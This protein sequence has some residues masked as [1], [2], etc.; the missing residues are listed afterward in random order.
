LRVD[1]HTIIGGVMGGDGKLRP[2]TIVSW[3][4]YLCDASFLVA[5]QSAPET[6]DAL[7]RAIR[8][9]VWPIYLGR[10]CC[11]P[12]RPPFEG[13]GDYPT[14]E[15][16]LSDWPWYRWDSGSQTIRVRAVLE[17][18]IP[19]GIHCRDEI[20]SRSRRTF[21]RRYTYDAPVTIKIEPRN[22]SGSASA[23][24]D[25]PCTSPD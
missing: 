23:G 19:T 7:A 2:G 22:P 14:L 6:I 12:S 16:A 4:A 13:L 10:R 1:Y 11:V 17:S 20:L 21:G 9:P 5:V 18:P 15:A 24:E 3:R 8:A 25:Q